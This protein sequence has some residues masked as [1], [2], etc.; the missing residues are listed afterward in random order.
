MRGCKWQQ[1]RTGINNLRHAR[2][3][4]AFHWLEKPLPATAT[5]TPTRWI[6]AAKCH[7]PCPTVT[8][9]AETNHDRRLSA[10]QCIIAIC[11]DVLGMG[12]SVTANTHT[13]S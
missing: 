13:A 7:P 11:S 4:M 1:L 6:R 9:L 10:C 12:T 2:A 8:T 5:V 3:S